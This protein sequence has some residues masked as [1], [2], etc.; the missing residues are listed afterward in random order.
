MT[1]EALPFEGEDAPTTGIASWAAM[2]HLTKIEEL[3]RMLT[4]TSWAV[5]PDPDAP[6]SFYIS[7]PPETAVVAEKMTEQDARAVVALINELPEAL[8]YFEDLARLWDVLN[9]GVLGSDSDELS[10]YLEIIRKYQMH[11]AQL[12]DNPAP[13]P[14]VEVAGDISFMHVGHYLK[15]EDLYEPIV[16]VSQDKDELTVLQVGSSN[17]ILL[18]LPKTFSVEVDV[19]GALAPPPTPETPDE[20]S[21]ESQPASLA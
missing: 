1:E 13:I 12:E 7:G 18:Y 3:V 10:T 16:S 6:G 9:D 4:P 14:P 15:H 20:A 21:S 8:E 11:I 5:H 17:N 19:V 2:S